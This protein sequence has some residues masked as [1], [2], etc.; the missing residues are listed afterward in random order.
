MTTILKVEVDSL[1]ELIC[2]KAY[3]YCK[4]I[5][6]VVPSGKEFKSPGYK[7]SF[8]HEVYI[9]KSLSKKIMILE[10]I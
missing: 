6:I 4:K 8:K 7:V 10:A 3:P 5:V 2:I 9:H 1:V